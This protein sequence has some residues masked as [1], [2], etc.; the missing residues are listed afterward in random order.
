MDERD[1]DDATID[2]TVNNVVDQHTENGEFT[3]S[4]D[5][6]VD[7]AVRRL[8][9]DLPAKDGTPALRTRVNAS[10]N[11]LYPPPPAS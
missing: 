7:E 8:G 2:D 6:I 5:K 11:A 1:F 3:I 4:R 10:L 9:G